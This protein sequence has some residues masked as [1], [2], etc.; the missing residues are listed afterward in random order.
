M[1]HASDPRPHRPGIEDA[2][3]SK[4]SFTRLSTPASAGIL[5]LEHRDA[6]RAAAAAPAPASHVRP[7]RA[8]RGA[9]RRARRVLVRARQRQPDKPAGPIVDHLG[10]R[11][12]A[13]WRRERR[14][15]SSARSKAARA[16]GR[17]TGRWRRTATH[18]GSRARTHATRPRPAWPRPRRKAFSSSQRGLAVATDGATPSR[19]NAVTALPAAAASPTRGDRAPAHAPPP[20]HRR[21]SRSRRSSP[22][23]RRRHRGPAAAP[24][25]RSQRRGRV[26]MRHVGHDCQR[27]PG[28][29]QQLAQIVAGDVLHHPPARLEGL[30][31]ARDRRHAEEMVTRG[32]RP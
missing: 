4:L 26:L 31:A 7:C 27:A 18:R 5:R 13:R 23:S 1:P 20:R 21:P 19:R 30:A 28:A 25:P 9:R 11:L 16:P 6:P 29:G 2:P 3:G 22:R 12:G 32:A 24:S 14:H 17:P 8:R 15:R 10:I